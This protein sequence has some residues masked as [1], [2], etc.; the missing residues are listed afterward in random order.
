MRHSSFLFLIIVLATAAAQ[1]QGGG[2]PGAPMPFASS[3]LKNGLFTNGNGWTGTRNWQRSPQQSQQLLYLL[4][5]QSLY[6]PY[7]LYPPYSPDYA[8]PSPVFPLPSAAQGPVTATEPGIAEDAKA[9]AA[10]NDD[11]TETS[12]ASC[13][14]GLEVVHGPSSPPVDDDHPALVALKNRWAY[15]VRKYWT[16]GTMFYFI[17]SQGDHKQIPIEQVERI[18]PASKGKHD[19]QGL[20]TSQ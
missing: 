1:R 2:T 10:T 6:P 19:T 13:N 5:W 11:D 12:S 18:Y 4:P 17:T 14:A 7:P 20:V 3:T 9:P 16:K 15:T 8:Q